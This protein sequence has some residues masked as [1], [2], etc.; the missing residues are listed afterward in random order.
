MKKAVASTVP[1][2]LGE[3]V[4]ALL[5]QAGVKALKERI[6]DE[7]GTLIFFYVAPVYIATYLGLVTLTFYGQ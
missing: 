2:I 6:A 4:N 1:S 3:L 5:L 7:D